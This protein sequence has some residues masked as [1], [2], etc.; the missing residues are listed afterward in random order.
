MK[1]IS[2][3]ILNFE[4]QY[5]RLFYHLHMNDV[6]YFVTEHYTDYDMN[7]DFYKNCTIRSVDHK[8]YK[9][10]KIGINLTIVL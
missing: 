4:R 6:N 9:F 10:F 7:R 1:T 5:N 8:I 3:G 2:K